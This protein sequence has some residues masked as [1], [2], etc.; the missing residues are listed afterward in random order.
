MH[1]DPIRQGVLEPDEIERGTT[2]FRHASIAR[3][4]SAARTFH[5]HAA[6]TA[7]TCAQCSAAKP[8]GFA[9][10]RATTPFN[11]CRYRA[12]NSA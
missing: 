5:V 10:H 1:L 8:A 12:A 7:R 4:H 9:S 6:F 3:S 11:S 2:Y